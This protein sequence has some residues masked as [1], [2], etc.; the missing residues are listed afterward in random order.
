M[1]QP[2]KSYS[3]PISR[4]SV[5]GLIRWNSA[6]A[7]GP[8]VAAIKGQC[9]RQCQAATTARQL[10]PSRESTTPAKPR[11]D[12]LHIADVTRLRS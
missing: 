6:A 3:N 2:S 7:I 11:H 12:H 4:P 8:K 1:H 9:L 5:R 10:Q